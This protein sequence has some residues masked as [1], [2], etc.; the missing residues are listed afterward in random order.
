MTTPTKRFA[1]DRREAAVVVVIDDDGTTF[2]VPGSALPKDCRAEGAVFDAPVGEDGAPIWKG[3]KR[4][5]A[6]ERGRLH[7]AQ[8]RIERLRRRDPGGDVEL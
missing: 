5:R 2:D 1:V 7:E 3:A 4:N 6:A 8:E